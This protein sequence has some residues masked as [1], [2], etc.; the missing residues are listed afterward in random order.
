MPRGRAEAGRAQIPPT[1]AHRGIKSIFSKEKPRIKIVINS[2]IQIHRERRERESP[3]Y[4]HIT[5]S[6][7]SSGC[8]HPLPVNFFFKFRACYPP[9]FHIHLYIQAQIYTYT[10][11][12]HLELYKSRC[13]MLAK[14]FDFKLASICK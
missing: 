8:L 9:N 7:L 5:K 10:I 3:F 13:L 2:I 4:T 1:P 11:N 14:C 6:S 12:Y